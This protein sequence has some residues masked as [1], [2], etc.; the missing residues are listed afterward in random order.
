MPDQ[1]LVGEKAH[2]NPLRRFAAGSQRQAF[3]P[4]FEDD[5]ANAAYFLKCP[6]F[7]LH[8]RVSSSSSG[9][10]ISTVPSLCNPVLVEA[11]AVL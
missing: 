4:A 8:G 7:R 10:S 1:A 2:S 6:A 3:R 9:I 11:L 5:P